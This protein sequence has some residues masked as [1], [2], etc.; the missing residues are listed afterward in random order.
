MSNRILTIS[1]NTFRES[2]RDKILYNLVLFVLLITLAAI[3]LGDLTA[4]VE[5]RFITN[6]GLTSALIFG[7][8]IA[9]FVGVGLVSKEIEKRTVFAVFAK[10]VSRAE[11]LIGKYLGLCLTLLINLLVMGIGISLALFYV[12][13]TNLIS[14]VWSSLFLIYLELCI[15][16]AA[17]I[18]FSSFSSPTLSAL[19]ALLIFVIGNFSSGLKE[20]AASVGVASTEAFF[21]AVYYILP[22]FAHLSFITPAA[23][24]ILPSA[25]QTFYSILY[26]I[27]YITVLLT[28]AAMIFSR[29]NFK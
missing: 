2:I 18:L 5:S 4:G 1:R 14:A 8:F 13:G 23:H 20:F 26:S 9:I 7:S 16:T 28:A 6:L 24:G 29:R 27:A 17:A 25:P 21:T 19:F 12:K 11:F 10:P 22:N 3:F 15:L